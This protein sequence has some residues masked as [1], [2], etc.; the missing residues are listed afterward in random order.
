[1]PYPMVNGFSFFKE[2]L[3]AALGVE[4]ILDREPL[5]LKDILTTNYNYELI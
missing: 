4:H 2:K 5:K 3:D 1:M